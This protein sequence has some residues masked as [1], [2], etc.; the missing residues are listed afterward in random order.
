MEIRPLVIDVHVRKEQQKHHWEIT[1]SGALQVH[2][3][4]P[5]SRDANQ[6]LIKTIA[7]ALGI[8]HGHITIVHGDESGIKRLKIGGKTVTF[9]ELMTTLGAV[10][11]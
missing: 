4:E 1:P 2:H 11:A 5:E 6:Y 9:N 8:S 10:K 3:K 7:E